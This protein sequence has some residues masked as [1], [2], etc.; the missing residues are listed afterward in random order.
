MTVG[1]RG[2]LRKKARLTTINS[3]P[4]SGAV[5]P[6]LSVAEAARLLDVA[7]RTAYM[8]LRRGELPGAVEIN[9][10]AYVRRAALERWLDAD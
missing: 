2:P 8:W 4:A 5:R 1:L 6:L 9:G 7:P 3:Q 10:R